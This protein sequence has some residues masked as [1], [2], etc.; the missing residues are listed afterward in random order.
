MLHDFI[1]C[2]RVRKTEE[3]D[4]KKSSVKGKRKK[5]RKLQFDDMEKLLT[6]YKKYFEYKF[7]HLNTAGLYMDPTQSHILAQHIL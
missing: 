4:M 6:W 3:K 7:L 5:G 1:L 2:I